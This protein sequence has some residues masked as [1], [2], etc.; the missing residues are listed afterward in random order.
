M[1]G[2]SATKLLGEYISHFRLGSTPLYF[3]FST[4]RW[5]APIHV[6][7]FIIWSNLSIIEYHFAITKFVIKVKHVFK[8]KFKPN[9]AKEQLVIFLE[10]I[11]KHSP[12]AHRP[13]GSSTRFAV[14]KNTCFREIF[15]QNML[16]N[17]LFF[18][19]SWKKANS[20]GYS[21][22]APVGLRKLPPHPH[23]KSTYYFGRFR[24]DA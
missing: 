9:Y 7:S 4:M 17:V 21:P 10:K 20:V 6:H 1:W 3:S 19:K 8:Q 14:I 11:E 15:D 5:H 24:H 18:G 22:P 23:I 2:G 12:G 13:W 16:K